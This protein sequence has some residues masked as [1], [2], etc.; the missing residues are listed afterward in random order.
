MTLA[1]GCTTKTLIRLGAGNLKALV[2]FIVTGFFAFLMTKTDFYALAFHNWVQPLS[3]DLT[4]FNLSGQD[5][6][7]LLAPLFGTDDA[8]L[9]R[10]IGGMIIVIAIL[11]FILR[12]SGLRH[13][14]QNWLGGIIVGLCVSA[15]WYLTGGPWGQAW[16]EA[17]AWA[18]E[19]PLGVGVQSLTFVN[20]SGETLT[21][22]ADPGNF[23]LLTFGVV[24]VIGVLA[25]AFT[26]ALSSG[27]LRLEWFISWADF[28]RHIVGAALMGIGGILALGCTI[29]Q[30]V[31]GASTL[32]LGSFLALGATVLGCAMITLK[33]EYYR[34][35]YEDASLFHALVAS[36]A[37]LHLLPN[38]MRRLAAM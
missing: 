16:I 23:L 31:S 28:F 24:A 34:I 6:G 38:S 12:T 33:V 27:Q 25:G 29:G 36:L 26:S 9:I 11:L 35:L 19:P 10:S 18:D 21:W 8:L 30:G 4:R 14:G 2:V 17:S 1:S 5:L 3:I 22:L 20:P 13:N 32:A 7:N 15:G 37:D